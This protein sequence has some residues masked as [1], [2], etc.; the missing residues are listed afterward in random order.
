[1]NS[2]RKTLYIRRHQNFD[3]R[4]EHF[5]PKRLEPEK[6]KL[7]KDEA[8]KGRSQKSMKLQRLKS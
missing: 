3:R 2:R 8:T 5:E 1:M 6:Q 7:Q 4:I